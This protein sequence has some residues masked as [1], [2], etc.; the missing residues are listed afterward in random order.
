MR[1]I[2]KKAWPEFYDLFISGKR[3]FELRLADFDLETGDI[4]VLREY[5][6]K[7]KEYTGRC[8][9]FK[10]KKVERSA[11]DLLQFYNVDEVKN[12]GF[13]II[14]FDRPVIQKP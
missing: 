5:D 13:Y 11:K 2:E 1:K 4:L 3:K 8:A 7:T 9:E 14:E 10:C 12:C 6:P